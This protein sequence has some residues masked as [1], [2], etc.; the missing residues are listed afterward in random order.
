MLKVGKCLI[1]TNIKQNDFKITSEKEK[2]IHIAES[3]VVFTCFHHTE[4]ILLF[5]VAC[6]NSTRIQEEDYVAAAVV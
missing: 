5:T 1:H 4:M 3:Q 2:K 6:N